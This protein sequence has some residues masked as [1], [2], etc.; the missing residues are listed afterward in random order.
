[1]YI[2]VLA[3]G[4]ALV[5]S[6]RALSRWESLGLALS[7]TVA[8]A[9]LSCWSVGVT[10]A[11][12]L[13]SLALLWRWVPRV[14]AER[15]PRSRSIPAAE[16]F[17][18]VLL[19]IVGWLGQC[20]FWQLE[21][22]PLFFW[23]LPRA[24]AEFG[25]AGWV[26]S[27][28]GEPWR[29]ALLTGGAVTWL[30][31]LLARAFAARVTSSVWAR[32]VVTVS[33][34][35][36]STQALLAPGTPEDVFSRLWAMSVL[37]AASGPHHYAAYSLLPAA[38]LVSSHPLT[39]GA[40]LYLFVPKAWRIHSLVLPGL[41]ACILSKGI[42]WSTAAGGALLALHKGPLTPS[43]LMLLSLELWGP[44][45][46]LFGKVALA[47]YFAEKLSLHV[48]DSSKV[49]EPAEQWG[50]LIPKRRL[51]ALALFAIFLMGALPGEKSLNSRVLVASQKAKID[52]HLLLLPNS[53]ERWI[54]LRGSSFGVGSDLEE[55]AVVLKSLGAPSLFARPPVPDYRES[56]VVSMLAGRE[57]VGW[58]RSQASSPTLEAGLAS[59]FLSG[60]ERLL[61]STRV[62]YLLLGPETALTVSRS[63]GALQARDFPRSLPLHF[64]VTT[65]PRSHLDSNA[66][67]PLEITASNTLTY[68]I[69]LDQ[70]TKVRLE[71]RW[72]DGVVAGAPVS[73]RGIRLESGEK[74]ALRLPLRTPPLPALFQVN[75][76]FEGSDG[77][78]FIR[79]SLTLDGFRSR[80]TIP[81]LDLEERDAP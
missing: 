55:M 53:L 64:A 44:D 4:F 13:T 3:L 12:V 37:L 51:A 26:L 49:I 14:V 1:M 19:S 75:I 71:S 9:A 46:E 67:I 47:L 62:R 5:Y 35:L 79:Q 6:R 73:L 25:L 38:A 66:L 10:V 81:R 70:V 59:Y 29:T 80:S 11:L 34:C 69:V 22:P 8:T 57:W 74:L 2:P 27:M 52:L 41:L 58:E 56:A 15:E 65:P 50:L 30:T 60:Q 61:E 63:E 68:P 31:L 16:I 23:Q 45:W 28:G 20:G 76:V 7:S 43:L 48:K 54:E 36:G 42:G 32:I 40:F 72:D 39:A 78:W 21:P 24:E 17:V 77:D 18:L 33:L